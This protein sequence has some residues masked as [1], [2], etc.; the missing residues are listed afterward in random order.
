M[1][2]IWKDIEGYEGYYQVSNLGNVKALDRY[3]Q[4][5]DKY[6]HK[7]EK[8]KGQWKNP[9]G[10][11]VCKLSKDNKD[12]NIPVHILV[13]KTFIENKDYKDGWEVDRLD[14]DRT[15]NRVDNLEWVTHEENVKRAAAAGHMKHYG[16]DNPNYGN[17]TLKRKFEEYPELRALQSRKGKQ[18]GRAVPIKVKNIET[19][20]IMRFNYLREAAQYFIDNKITLRKKIPKLDCVANKLKEYILKN[21]IYCGYE[22]KFA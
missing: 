3:V 15:N 16:E 6:Q 7:K 4:K 13:A 2:E 1:T 8:I 5:G 17:N 12:V 18:N 10:Y 9:D 21:K 22:I 11:L 19:G 20:E 14:S